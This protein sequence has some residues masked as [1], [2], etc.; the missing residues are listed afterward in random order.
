MTIQTDLL[1]DLTDTYGDVI[2][3][4]TSEGNHR[5]KFNFDYTSNPMLLS[6]DYLAQASKITIALSFINDY[7]SLVKDDDKAHKIL[8]YLD[9]FYAEPRVEVSDGKLI[10]WEDYAFT[11]STFNIEDFSNR[12]ETIEKM[13]IEVNDMISTDDFYEDTYQDALYSGTIFEEKFKDD[14]FLD[15]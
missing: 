9:V 2:Y 10:V 6:V 15:K 14:A 3:R 4:E 7:N 12:L 1:T 5:Y 11:S 8:M 13:A